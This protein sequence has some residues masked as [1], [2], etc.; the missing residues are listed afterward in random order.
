MKEVASSYNLKNAKKFKS[1]EQYL[2]YVINE[3]NKRSK[4]YTFH[5]FLFLIDVL[6]RRIREN[7]N[8]IS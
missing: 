5:Q 7:M 2:E 3:I 8:I 4:K 6:I 1:T